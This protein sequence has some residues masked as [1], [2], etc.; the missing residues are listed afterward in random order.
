MVVSCTAL[1]LPRLYARIREL[2]TKLP[3]S[4]ST[5]SSARN[6]L[7]AACPPTTPTHADRASA[8]TEGH[9]PASPQA[10][11]AGDVATQR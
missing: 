8:S 9:K 6:S 10:S 5:C 3:Y 11:A 1:P 4:Y 7:C 2:H